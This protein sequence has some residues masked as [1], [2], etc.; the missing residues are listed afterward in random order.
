MSRVA[1]ELLASQEVLCSMELECSLAFHHVDLIV[2]QT[3]SGAY[4][5]KPFLPEVIINP[6]K[7]SGYLDTCFSFV[8]MFRTF[9]LCESNFV[10]NLNY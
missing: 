3:R 4:V 10:F 7:H 8:K 6:L 2:Q 5:I 9:V 1:A